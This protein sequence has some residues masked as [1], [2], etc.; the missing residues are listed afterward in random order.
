MPAVTEHT[1]IYPPDL[2]P[3]RGRSSHP[4]VVSFASA[5]D[6]WG[7]SPGW[8][9]ELYRR[10]CD[11]VRAREILDYGM[12]EKDVPLWDELFA[13]IPERRQRDA[14]RYIFDDPDAVIVSTSERMKRAAIGGFRGIEWSSAPHTVVDE[15]GDEAWSAPLMVD[16]ARSLV[17]SGR[18]EASQLAALAPQTRVASELGY[19]AYLDT[20]ALELSESVATIE[21][22]SP[23]W[24]SAP[25]ARL[26]LDVSQ[27][28]P[29]VTG[30]DIPSG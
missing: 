28:V 23:Y 16:M 7:A 20:T 6:C 24:V 9:T 3:A 13:L 19:A 26:S 25:M 14:I 10:A 2:R 4:R 17:I 21:A 29:A 27:D 15:Y 18:H 8:R 1:C 22:A 11:W 30:Q 12:E 5:G